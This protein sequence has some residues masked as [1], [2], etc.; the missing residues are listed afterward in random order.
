MGQSTPL[1]F[2]VTPY[3]PQVQRVGLCAASLYCHFTPISL[4]LHSGADPPADRFRTAG[5]IRSGRSLALGDTEALRLKQEACR[6]AILEMQDYLSHTNPAR[7]P[8]PSV[9]GISQEFDA[10]CKMHSLPLHRTWR[11][12]PQLI[13]KECVPTARA[14]SELS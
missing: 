12:E 7:R 1:C 14:K 8:H 5:D 10:T 4:T 3:L 11:A 9:D 13:P 2:C 6:V